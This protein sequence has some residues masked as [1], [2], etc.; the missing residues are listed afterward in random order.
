MSLL[1]ERKGWRRYCANDI[2]YFVLL[3]L[4][5]LHEVVIPPQDTE[6]AVSGGAPG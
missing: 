6:G 2:D 1:F 3:T 5:E 4:K